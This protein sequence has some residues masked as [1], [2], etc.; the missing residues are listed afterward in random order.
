VLL[1]APAYREA[2]ASRFLGERFARLKQKNA[3]SSVAGQYSSLGVAGDSTL[4]EL[5]NAGLPGPAP[6]TGGL[7][8]SFE[9]PGSSAAARALLDASGQ[10]KYHHDL[11]K[12]AIEGSAEPS[13]WYH[14]I[15]IDL[16]EG[17]PLLLFLN[18][19]APE[20]FAAVG[21]RPAPDGTLR[22][23][24]YLNAVLGT[25][26]GGSRLMR[27]VTGVTLLVRAERA[28]RIAEAMALFGYTVTESP[29]GL[30]LRHPDLT[31]RLRVGEYAVER[32]TEIEIR[33]SEGA[34]E[35]AAYQFG[36]TSQ[37]VIETDSTA[38]WK[39]D[40]DS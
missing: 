4:V 34:N 20:Y 1:D 38:R 39:F 24:D 5:F 32:I 12:R 14:L 29:R 40:H 35:A 31:I 9:E 28:R 13:P 26:G 6:L 21:A 3:D 25:P 8:F 30:D 37:L 10:V 33:L 7:V 11:V 19:V 27:D 22:R 23:R 36:R 15:S 18:E 2:S 17:S 16:G